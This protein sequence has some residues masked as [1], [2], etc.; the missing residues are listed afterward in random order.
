MGNGIT[1]CL[2]RARNRREES[3]ERRRQ[4]REEIWLTQEYGKRQRME[5]DNEREREKRWRRE[6]QEWEKAQRNARRNQKPLVTAPETAHI[7]PPPPSWSILLS[8]SRQPTHGP[9]A[10]AGSESR[11][12]RPAQNISGTRSQNGAWNL[13]FVQGL[14]PDNASLRTH[15]SYQGRVLLQKR[16][17]SISVTRTSPAPTN[18][19]DDASMYSSASA[20]HRTRLQEHNRGHRTGGLSHDKGSIGSSSLLFSDRDSIDQKS[21]SAQGP[22]SERH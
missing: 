7:P 12:N 13:D 10:V 1:H 8:G 6:L 2:R 3:R 20:Q 22:L 15:A 4:H 21:T 5:N 11:Y 9:S 19:Q 16:N 18:V 17:R 14:A